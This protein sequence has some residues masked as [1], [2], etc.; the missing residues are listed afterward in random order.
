[1]SRY[2][3]LFTLFC[4]IVL[5]SAG[6][7]VGCSNEALNGPSDPANSDAAGALLKGSCNN[8][9]NNK[10]KDKNKGDKNDKKKKDKKDNGDKKKKDK[11]D[12]DDKNK[13]DKNKDDKNKDDKNNGN[14]GGSEC[15]TPPPAPQYDGC[16]EPV[17]YWVDNPSDWPAP[18]TPDGQFCT[19]TGATFY[20][21]ISAPVNECDPNWIVKLA[22]E[23]IAALLNKTYNNG[24]IPKD[25]QD[26]INEGQLFFNGRDMRVPLT[27][28]E[29]CQAERL[30]GILA[31]FNDGDGD[32]PACE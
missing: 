27:A 12:K 32:L 30:F 5:L 9:S 14:S 22:H 24:D 28:A 20:T 3:N 19:F 21:F 7:I 17:D 4:T 31:P 15:N 13:G 10:S 23:Y 11:K 2:L 26:A 18:F 6:G 16:V 8:N 29:I 1:M 25:I